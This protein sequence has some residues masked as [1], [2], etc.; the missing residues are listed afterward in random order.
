MSFILNTK[1]Q[2]KAKK[3]Y[4]CLDQSNLAIDFDKK[5]V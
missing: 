4:N 5:K 2:N 1:I 3:N